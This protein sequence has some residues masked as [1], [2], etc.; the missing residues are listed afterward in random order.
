[1]QRSCWPPL[2]SSD[3]S[4]RQQ[5]KVLAAEVAAPVVQAAALVVAAAAVAE[6]LRL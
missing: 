2:S 4:L 1:L 3:R 6:T 5:H